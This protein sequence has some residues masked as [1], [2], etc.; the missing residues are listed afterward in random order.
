[1]E[2]VPRKVAGEV[3]EGF[4]AGARAFVAMEERDG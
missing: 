3:E 4:E 1:V 2:D